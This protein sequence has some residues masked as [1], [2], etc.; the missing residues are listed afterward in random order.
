M[1]LFHTSDWHLGQNLH[2]QERDFEHACFLEWLLRQLALHS[3]DVLLIAGDIFDTVNPPVKAQERLYDFIVSAH[4]QQ[5]GLT[6]VMI[7][8]NHDSGSRIELPAPLMRRLRTHA[9]GRVLWLDDGQ[10][11]SERLLLPLPDASGAIAGWCLA[12][13]FLRPAEVTGAHLGDDYLRGIGQ[14][15]EWLIAAANAKRQPGQALVAISHA[16]MAG[17]S[18]SE[19]SERSLIIGNAEALPASLFGPSISY[20][21]L[22]HLHKPQKVNGEER[23]RYSGSP[24]PLSFSEIG[25]QHQILDIQLDGETLV[26]VE[27]RLIP[28]AVNLQRLGPAPLAEILLQ[29]AELPDIDLLAEEQRQPWLE[30]RVRLD[31][32]QPDLRQQVESALQGKAVRL[33]RIAAEYAGNGGHEGDDGAAQLVELD[34]LS[35][36]DLFSRAWLDSYGSEVDEQTLKDFAQLL[37][38]VQHEEEQP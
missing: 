15:H 21:A 34:Q 5:P 7:A 9:L 14:V 25:Y 11:D 2:G 19:D 8:G 20:V 28:R 31:E 35:P 22:G 17:G 38:E 10:L 13:P 30:V 16:H 27:P 3:P 33:V 26:S 1:R 36:Q 32:P 37:Q 23:I 4:E 29:L 24:I 12:L 18:V 6:I